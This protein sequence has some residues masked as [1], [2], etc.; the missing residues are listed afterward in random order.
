MA[1]PQQESSGG[2][3]KNPCEVEDDEEDGKN[4]AQRSHLAGES[5]GCISYPASLT[6]DNRIATSPHIVNNNNH[7]IQLNSIMD[8]LK[9]RFSTLCKSLKVPESMCKKAMNHW[10]ELWLNHQ[11]VFHDSPAEA[12]FG[13]ALYKCII[14]SRSGYCDLDPY[15]F[16][17]TDLL[18]AVDVKVKDFFMYMSRLQEVQSSSQ[19]V[20][21][22]LQQ[23]MKRYI[24]TSP[25]FALFQRIFP[26]IF[27]QNSKNILN[28]K[29]KS[30]TVQSKMKLCWILFLLCKS[31][32]MNGNAEMISYVHMLICIVHYVA[33]QTTADMLNSPY[34]ELQKSSTDPNSTEMLSQLA[35]DFHTSY[36]ELQPV[37]KAVAQFVNSIVSYTN[38]NLDVDEMEKFYLKS[39]QA[40]GDI[41][42]LLFL[43]N[44][45]IVVTST[46]IKHRKPS[47]RPEDS[48]VAP[49]TPVRSALTV[50]QQLWKIL[51][52]IPEDP[53]ELLKD[54][55]DSSNA[56]MVTSISD[57]IEKYRKIFEKSFTDVKGQDSD[58]KR[59]AS[60]RFQ[61]IVKLYLHIFNSLLISE[62]RRVG[63]ASLVTM[64]RSDD[65]HKALM[66]C[67]AEVILMTY[68][69][70]LNNVESQNIQPD[71]VFPWV[72]KVFDL[73]AFCLFLVLESVLKLENKL[74]GEIC[75]HIQK[76]EQDILDCHAWKEGRSVF[77]IS[78]E[79]LENL[80]E[81]KNGE[82][83]TNLMMTPT[84]NNPNNS[85]F[86][87]YYYTTPEKMPMNSESNGQTVVVPSSPNSS[88][89]QRSRAIKQFFT[90]VCHLAFKRLSRLCESLE[91]SP[92]L[93]QKVWTCL[94]HC[95][96]HNRELLRN[97]HLD[98][99]MVCCLYG[100][101]RVVHQEIKFKSIV[102]VSK[103]ISL[104]QQEI[105]KVI[106]IQDGKTDSIV[107][108][109]NS[110]YLPTMK[111][112]ILQ[113]EP[114]KQTTPPLSSTP[115]SCVTSS[116]V[117]SVAGKKNFHVSYAKSP[118]FKTQ[119][120][121]TPRTD[122][123]YCFVEGVGSAEKLRNI[124]DTIAQSRAQKRLQFDNLDN[125]STRN[126]AKRPRDGMDA[127]ANRSETNT[128]KD[129]SFKPP[130][131]V[132][133]R[134]CTTP[135]KESAEK[136]EQSS[137]M[138]R[139]MSSALKKTQRFLQFDDIQPASENE[140]NNSADS[141]PGSLAVDSSQKE[142]KE[143][144][145]EK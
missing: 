48:V 29:V 104:A 8:H 109:Y 52:E 12:W 27:K 33:T 35:E 90:K 30:D 97:R 39:Y 18:K 62:Q 144:T 140:V 55:I 82:N 139:Y 117:F 25:M 105:F 5:S 137:P 26:Q 135:A 89:T 134:V 95:I 91:V 13:C 51:E 96:I 101:C 23:L 114:N 100:I 20:N 58:T 131:P 110:V 112:Y 76:I 38:G 1:H 32:Y 86:Y 42:E 66:A 98:Q 73:E 87:H 85:C 84:K 102:N 2:R 115:K 17:I 142:R 113:F 9:T 120:Q 119:G 28:Q 64:F 65:L 34:D 69:V 53:R 107:G 108:F 74:P 80:L 75:R 83:A 7:N 128:W 79:D 88:N 99:I 138:S 125:D 116:P 37:Q 6:G 124:N 68:N 129:P 72:L 92:E 60:E 145:M 111:T 10:E 44:D 126:T 43:V 94:V 103:E 130:T 45:P 133:S 81:A 41:N 127:S 15:V 4:L 93:T 19:A 3:R 57:R 67:S 24:I 54:Y 132:S 40:S 77:E 118:L 59:F 63:R 46:P 71:F 50:V 14:D 78:N 16:T 143:N 70:S 47:P 122:Q 11:K 61:I 136:K 56:S 31:S 141:R 22:H 36:K 106:L 49:L 123:L 21:T 121:L